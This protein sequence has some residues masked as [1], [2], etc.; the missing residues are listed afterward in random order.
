MKT[1]YVIL[2][3]NEALS[4][5]SSL[6]QACEAAG[7]PR[8]TAIRRIKKGIQPDSNKA[9]ERTIQRIEL[10]KNKKR[11]NLSNITHYAH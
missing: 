1:I 10:H 9:T 4:A 2:R 5:H 11:G 8:S 7:I 6:S 3:G